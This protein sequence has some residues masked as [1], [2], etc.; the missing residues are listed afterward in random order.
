[1]I[2]M[3]KKCKRYT[4]DY[5]V[6]SVFLQKLRSEDMELLEEPTWLLHNLKRRL[7]IIPITRFSGFFRSYILKKNF[8]PTCFVS[9]FSVPLGSFIFF[10]YRSYYSMWLL[11]V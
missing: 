7:K 1:M 6:S 3:S 11:M 5:C 4:F 2:K 10:L 8:C 9:Y